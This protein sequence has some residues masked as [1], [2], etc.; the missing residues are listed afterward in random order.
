MSLK[1][2]KNTISAT[3]VA[4]Y[5]HCQYQWY[6]ERKYGTKELRSLKK[7][8]NENMGYVDTTKSMFQKGHDFHNSYFYRDKTKKIL[9]FLFLIVLSFILAIL[10][11]L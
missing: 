9:F 3:E 1:N 5:T 7:Q 11:F 4:K 6:Y 10:I 8:H 2:N